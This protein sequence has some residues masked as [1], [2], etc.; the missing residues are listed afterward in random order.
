MV[1]MTNLYARLVF[2][3]ESAQHA[4]QTS[5]THLHML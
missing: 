4:L 3:P 1:I 5:P 2:I